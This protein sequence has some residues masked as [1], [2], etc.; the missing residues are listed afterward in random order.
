[1]IGSING[2]DRD[3]GRGSGGHPARFLLRISV[4]FVILSF[5]EYPSRVPRDVEDGE[6]AKNREDGR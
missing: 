2:N 1:M 4:A 3:G 6:E 5:P